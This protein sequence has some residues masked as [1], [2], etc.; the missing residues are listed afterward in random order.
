M[1]L[2]GLKMQANCRGVSAGEWAAEAEARTAGEEV[3]GGGGG[4]GLDP[5]RGGTGVKTGEPGGFDGGSQLCDKQGRGEGS[6]GMVE[7]LVLRSDVKGLTSQPAH[8]AVQSTTDAGIGGFDP[9]E[10]AIERNDAARGEGHGGMDRGDSGSGSV[11]R[12]KGVDGESTAGVDENLA[13]KTLSV[14]TSPAAQDFRGSVGDGRVGHAQ[15]EDPGVER[16]FA[17]GDG[18]RLRALAVAN[19][20]FPR[21]HAGAG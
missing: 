20:D 3:T 12:L 4:Q 17:P 10:H 16:G 19:H 18:A 14:K 6:S 15:P 2:E 21:R 13:A 9:E 5:A 8:K 7:G 11:R 1:L